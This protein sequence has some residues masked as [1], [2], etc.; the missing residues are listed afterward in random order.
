MAGG[1]AEGC[2]TRGIASRDEAFA[3]LTGLFN[4][5]VTPFDREARFDGRAFADTV[6]RMI[7]FGYD[8]LLI[9]GTYGEFAT[10]TAEERAQLFRAA[11]EAA[12]GRVPLLLCSASADLRAVRELTLLAAELGG[13]PMMMP[14]FVSE[15]TDEQIVAFFREVAP[16]SRTGIVIYNAPGVGITLTPSL[17]ARIAEIPGVI[18]LKQGDLAPSAVDQLLGKV[19]GKIRLFCASDLQMPGP[20]AVGFDGLSST[21]SGALPE[22]IRDSYRAFTGGDARKGGELYRRWYEYRSFARHAG[23]PQ[24]V[25]AA[26]RLRGWNGGHVRKPLLDLSETETAELSAIMERILQNRTGTQ[27]D[28]R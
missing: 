2:V 4:I 9:G 11:A 18:G 16:L 26:M 22:L 19:G 10:M 6:E 5:T 25:K 27:T 13:I 7:G 3:R 15:V 17:I 28:R 21:N 24:T 12:R 23:Q 1:E 14:P 8:G 20:A